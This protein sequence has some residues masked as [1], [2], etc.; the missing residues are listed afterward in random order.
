MISDEIEKYKK[1]LFSEDRYEQ[2]CAEWEENFVRNGSMNEFQYGY[3]MYCFGSKE[4]WF[5]QQKKIDELERQ[6][7]K[8]KN[9]EE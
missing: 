6:I 4:A 1:Q 7:E 5:L 2:V 3:Y 8:L 9:G